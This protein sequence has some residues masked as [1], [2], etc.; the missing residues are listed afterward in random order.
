MNFYWF[1]KYIEIVNFFGFI[2]WFRNGRIIL[3]ELMKLG[4]IFVEVFEKEKEKK[5]YFYY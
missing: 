2:D 3:L 1:N 5:K 4:V